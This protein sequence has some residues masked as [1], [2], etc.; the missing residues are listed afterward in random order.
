MSG[1]TPV[2]GLS[3][4]DQIRQVEAEMTR[5]IIAARAAADQRL[6]EARSRAVALKR[7]ARETGEQRGRMR[8]KEIIAEAETQAAMLAAQ[9]SEEAAILRHKGE[10]RMER[11]VEEAVSIVLG[12]Q[13]EGAEHEP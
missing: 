9:A 5:R 12:Q 2:D 1:A 13:G 11:G 7:Q 4:L 10:A 3:P 6:A 8:Y